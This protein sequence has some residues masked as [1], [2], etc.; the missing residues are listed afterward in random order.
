[1]VVPVHHIPAR[2]LLLFLFLLSF[3]SVLSCSRP[4]KWEVL[5][6]R[7]GVSDGMPLN[8]MVRGA[9]SEKYP[10]AWMFWILRSG[11]R[12]VL[13]DCGFENESLR[14]RWHIEAYRRPVDILLEIGIKPDDITDVVITHLHWDHVGSIHRFR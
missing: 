9:S 10:M 7:Y 12:T 8:K 11:D 13:V 6:A 2:R 1:M 14:R 5:C 3:L 4:A